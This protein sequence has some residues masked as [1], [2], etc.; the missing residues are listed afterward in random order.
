[1]KNMI[2]NEWLGLIRNR[3]FLYL[4]IFFATALILVT[5][6]GVLQNQTQL[7]AQQKAHQHIRVQWDEMEP[8][9]PH[10]AAHFGTYAFKPANVL[11]GIDEG[12]NALTGNV[13]KLEGHTQNELVYSEASQS[14]LISKFGK[15][16]PSL[17]LQ[18]LIPLF[19]IFLAFNTYNQERESGRLKLI[20]IQGISLQKLLISKTISI[21]LIGLFMMLFSVLAQLLFNIKSFEAD[22]LF[23]LTILFIGYGLY[24]L[25]ITALS[26]LL[27]AY[28]KK[29]TAS[30]AL[31]MS[32]WVLWTIFLPKIISNA[33]EKMHPLPS[34]IEFQKAMTEDRSKGIDGHN[35]SDKRNQELKKA[36]LAKY[37]ADSLAELPVNFDGLRMQADED[38]G[39]KVWDKHFSGNYG[40]LKSH[41][42]SYQLSG[43]LNPFASVQNLSM[44]A[45]G[46]DMLHHIHFLKSAENY[47]RVFIKTLNDKHAYGGSKTGDWA[48][49][50]DKDFFKSVKDFEY[51]EPSFMSMWTNYL[52]DFAA[53][54][55]WLILVI[56]LLRIASKR[57][58]II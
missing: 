54:L 30:L 17:L 41:K 40:K 26:I 15:L 43:F 42:Q 38:Y 5:G 31:M 20:L 4:S 46:T 44:G 12:V 22:T 2:L 28:F 23:R 50:A 8:G 16:K 58:S 29:S 11:N 53:L 27:S 45:T 56:T 24:Y 21:W 36:I 19:L 7:E 49:K 18:F 9:N 10:R 57:I 6:F 39:N 51:R 34:R 14:L 37:K 33:V 25:I 1:M 47:R 3:I 48:W 35:P 55:V 32:I 13:L 52:M